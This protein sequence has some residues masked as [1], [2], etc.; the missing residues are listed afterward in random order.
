MDEPPILFALERTLAFIKTKAASRTVSSRRKC[1][2][3]VL[4]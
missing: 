2:L 3:G 4:P 1:S